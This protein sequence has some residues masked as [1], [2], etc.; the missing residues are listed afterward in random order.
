[1]SSFLNQEELKIADKGI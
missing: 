1:V